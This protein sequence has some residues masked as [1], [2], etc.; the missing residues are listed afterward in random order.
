MKEKSQLEFNLINLQLSEKEKIIFCLECQQLRI[1]NYDGV[2]YRCA[3]CKNH[4]VI[5]ILKENERRE[6]VKY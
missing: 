2:F 1:F 3:Y 5:N 6:P 4:F